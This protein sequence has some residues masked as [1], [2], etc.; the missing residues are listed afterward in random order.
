MYILNVFPSALYGGRKDEI[1]V[2]IKFQESLT[3]LKIRHSNKK[4]YE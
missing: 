1:S 2:Y 4:I 3:F